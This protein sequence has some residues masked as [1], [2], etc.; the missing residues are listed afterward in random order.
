[1]GET[2]ALLA[3]VFEVDIP[4]ANPENVDPEAVAQDLVEAYKEYH[5]HFVDI[6][7]DSAVWEE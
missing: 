3:V 7:V 2:V 4:E 5:P 6:I 1:M